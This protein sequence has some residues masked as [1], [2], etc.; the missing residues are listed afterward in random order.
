LAVERAIAEVRP[1]LTVICSSACMPPIEFLKAC[2]R[3]RTRFSVISQTNRDSLWPTDREAETLRMAATG[4]AR[5][6][7]VSDANRGLF[8]SQI[9]ME[10][11]RA[12]VIH[13]PFNVST[14]HALA[15]PARAEAPVRMAC[16]SRL[17]FPSKGQDLLLEALAG[18]A[19]EDRDWRVTFFGTG[20]NE[21]TLHRLIDRHP[22][23]N[24]F[25]MLG[26]VDGV[27]KIWATHHALLMGSRYEG[28]PLAAVE[29]MMCGR[30]VIAPATAGIPE[31]VRDGQTGF[32][33]PV[34]AGRLLAEALERAWSRRAEWRAMG[35]QAAREIRVLVPPDPG[36]ALAERLAAL[37]A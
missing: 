32:L 27:E 18:E 1:N 2:L 26:H 33:A 31:I 37:A 28:C 17:H 9:A 14:D 25:A 35:E 6:Y 12:S 21:E 8:Q 16:V 4:A 11:P 13:N 30:I 10:L 19:W 29:A 22:F 7:F 3:T 5:W 15:W 23:G 20:Q 34:A 24:R 36:K